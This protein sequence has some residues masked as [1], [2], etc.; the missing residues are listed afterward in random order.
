MTE[1]VILGRL[2]EDFTRVPGLYVEGKVLKGTLI[3]FFEENDG[4]SYS[5]ERFLHLLRLVNRRMSNGYGIDLN[6]REASFFEAFILRWVRSQWS[7]CGRSQ[8]TIVAMLPPAITPYG[9]LF[10]SRRTRQISTSSM[11][12]CIS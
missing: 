12:F 9:T 5:K 1:R 7:C 4:P 10:V 6:I 2:V 8:G 3:V 11:S